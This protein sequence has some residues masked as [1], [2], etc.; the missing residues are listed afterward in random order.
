MRLDNVA[1]R[2]I[3]RYAFRILLTSRSYKR[4]ADTTDN[5]VSWDTS[6]KLD[7]RNEISPTLSK[8][9]GKKRKWKGYRIK[10]Q[11]SVVCP[12]IHTFVLAG[13]FKFQIFSRYISRITPRAVLWQSA[14]VTSECGPL[15]NKSMR[16]KKKNPSW[17]TPPPFPS[18]ISWELGLRREFFIIIYVSYSLI[19]NRPRHATLFF[20]S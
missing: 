10:R 11:S 8:K 4:A 5:G 18:I 20:L 13:G 16:I 7:T 9:R 12:L 2:I 1:S 3:N 17:H 14:V 19:A 6:L 15:M